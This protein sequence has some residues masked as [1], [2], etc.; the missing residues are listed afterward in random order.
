MCGELK[1]GLGG[2]D[3]H[4]WMNNTGGK[5]GLMRFLLHYF[6]LILLCTAEVVCVRRQPRPANAAIADCVLH[7]RC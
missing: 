4:R 6:A 5:A 2:N 3:N 7:A 1:V